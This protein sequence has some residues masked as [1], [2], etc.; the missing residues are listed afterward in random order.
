MSVNVEL[1]QM[2]DVPALGFCWNPTHTFSG[3]SSTRNVAEPAKFESGITMAVSVTVPPVL[4]FFPSLVTVNANPPL[5]D[6]IV[7]VVVEVLG[8]AAPDDEPAPAA[9]GVSTVRV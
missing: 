7:V 3:T 6:G 9:P 1:S 4:S 5:P 8:G 2:D